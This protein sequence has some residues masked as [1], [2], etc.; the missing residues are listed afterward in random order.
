MMPNHV[1]QIEGSP[2]EQTQQERYKIFVYYGKQQPAVLQPTTDRWFIF[3]DGHLLE[4][5]TQYL[6]T[7][8]DTNKPLRLTAT[9]ILSQW[10]NSQYLPVNLSARANE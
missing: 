2:N 6:N 8:S 4:Y 9:E 7:S 5:S 10:R 3:K 1:I